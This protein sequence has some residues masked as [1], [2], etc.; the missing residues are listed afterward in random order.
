MKTKR[1]IV[2]RDVYSRISWSKFKDLMLDYGF[3]LGYSEQNLNVIFNQKV[4]DEICL[5]YHEKKGFVLFAE[6]YMNMV[7]VSRIKV[8]GEILGN[9]ES[10]NKTQKEILKK[11]KIKYEENGKTKDSIT[12]NLGIK[13]GLLELLELISE[14]FELSSI[15]NKT[16]HMPCC[17]ETENNKENLASLAVERLKRSDVG[18]RRIVGI[19]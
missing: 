5:F 8:Y 10:F 16:C 17:F 18:L 6:S 2:G 14:H 1:F 3:K 12:F 19:E 9:L 11:L 13:N 7:Y 4:E 15:W